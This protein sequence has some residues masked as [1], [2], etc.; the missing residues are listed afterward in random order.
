MTTT[1]PDHIAEFVE[2]FASTW[3]QPS[4]ERLN[5]LLHPEVR[6]VQPLAGEIVG[7]DAA[8]ALW[9][10]TFSALPDLRGDVLSWAG[11][12]DVVLIELRMQAQVPGGRIEWDLVD[13]ITLADG[14]VRERVSYFDPT[15]LVPQL[16][17]HPAGWPNLVRA[18]LR[19]RRGATA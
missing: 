4:P 7:L 11:R 6:L 9:E 3:R 12:G 8:R 15:R 16:L 10:R 18:N 14:L 19:G 5:A 17:R 13:R 1:A 2:R